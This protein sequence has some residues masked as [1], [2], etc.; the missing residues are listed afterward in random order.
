[1]RNAA[2]IALAL[3]AGA[4]MLGCEQ[5]APPKADPAPAAGGG[6]GAG[7]QDE[8]PKYEAPSFPKESHTVTGFTAGTLGGANLPVATGS[9]TL[10]YSFKWTGPAAPGITFNPNS[11][12]LGGTPTTAGPYAGTYR[13]D[14]GRN[15]DTMS[16]H[17][18]VAPAPTP[19]PP[20]VAPAPR[21]PYTQTGNFPAITCR[22]ISGDWGG[23]ATLPIPDSAIRGMSGYNGAMRTTAATAYTWDAF[24][25]SYTLRNGGGAVFVLYEFEGTLVLGWGATSF[26]TCLDVSGLFA[27]P[28]SISQWRITIRY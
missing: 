27:R 22:L 20:P 26:S 11:Q 14:D 13:V 5:A 24:P 3:V 28:G 21:Q 23:Y 15:H 16:V 25:A 19:A 4:L 2:I 9:L 6:G 12:R 1:M 8:E 17:L 7:G 18:T 10:T